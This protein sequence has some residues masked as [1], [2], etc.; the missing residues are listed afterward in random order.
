MIFNKMRIAVS[1]ILHEIQNHKFNQELATGILPKEKFIYYVIQDSLYL[2]DF[3]KALAITAAKLSNNEQTQ[4]F[5]EFALD[6]IKAENSLHLNYLAENNLTKNLNQ[7][8]N[9]TCFMYTNF[10]LKT[11]SLGSVEE[12]VASLLPC[13][14]VYN[15]VGSSI[16]TKPIK[17]NPYQKWISLYSSDQFNLSVSLAINITNALG[18]LASEGTQEKMISSFLRSTQLEWLFWNS[19]YYQE[20]W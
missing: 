7:E 16:A 1:S 11:A 15:K 4:Q 2:P 5:L 9:P 14:W 18:N 3:S 17:N 19:A 20:Q 8:Q 10:L 13:F 12:A 6:A